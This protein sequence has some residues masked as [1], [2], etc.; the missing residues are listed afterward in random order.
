MKYAV[1][2][3]MLYR[4]EELIHVM[5]HPLL[6]QV[7]WPSLDRLIQILVHYLKDECQSTGW[8]IVEYFYE[9]YYVR[10]WIQFL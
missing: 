6:R 4:F 5:L 7:V 9:L 8:L 3:H 2:V 10:V 1:S